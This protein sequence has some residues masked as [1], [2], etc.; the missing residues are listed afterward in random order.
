MHH[1][2][3]YLE[4]ARPE[5]TV[6]EDDMHLVTAVDKPPNPSLSVYRTGT[7]HETDP[8]C[9]IRCLWWCGANAEGNPPPL[10]TSSEHTWEPHHYLDGLEALYSP[11]STIDTPGIPGTPAGEASEF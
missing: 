6:R 10:R 4:C 3:I 8:H 11:V 7:G 2:T 9:V 1:R 5:E